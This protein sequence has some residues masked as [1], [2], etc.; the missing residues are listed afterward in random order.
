MKYNFFIKMK[1][2]NFSGRRCHEEAACI[3]HPTKYSPG[4]SVFVIHHEDADGEV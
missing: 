3:P 4:R 2:K 1:K